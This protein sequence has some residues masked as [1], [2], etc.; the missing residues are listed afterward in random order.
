MF[1]LTWWEEAGTK[2]QLKGT[3]TECQVSRFAVWHSSQICTPELLTFL[4][5]NAWNLPGESVTRLLRWSQFCFVPRGIILWIN[6]Q[7]WAPRQ[8][9]GDEFRLSP[10]SLAQQTA[11][12][13]PCS[14]PWSTS[15]LQILFPNSQ[16]PGKLACPFLPATK[17]LSQGGA[18]WIQ[19]QK[20]LILKKKRKKDKKKKPSTGC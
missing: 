2:R 15:S 19:V 9:A 12:S 11:A 14:P 18:F 6:W 3:P 4:A 13:P 1:A 5:T 17:L 10:A 16:P 8:Q 20:I 7:R